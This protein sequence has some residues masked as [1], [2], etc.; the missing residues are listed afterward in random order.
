MLKEVM[1][2]KHGGLTTNQAL[3]NFLSKPLLSLEVAAT[4]IICDVIRYL[5]DLT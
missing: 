1:K 2:Q 4:K 3:L 5:W